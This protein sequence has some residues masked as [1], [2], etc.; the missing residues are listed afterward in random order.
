MLHVTQAQ[1]FRPVATY[2]ALIA[3]ARAQ[4]P[5]QFAFRTQRATSSRPPGLRSI[6]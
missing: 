1:L 6:C 5:E 2:L 3:L 4:A